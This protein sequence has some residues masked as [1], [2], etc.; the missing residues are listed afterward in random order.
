V[1]STR[2]APPP[3]E[4]LSD[5]HRQSDASV[6]DHLDRRHRLDSDWVVRIAEIPFGPAGRADISPPGDRDGAIVLSTC[7]SRDAVD[8]RPNDSNP[9]SVRYVHQLI[10][11]V[12]K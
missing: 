4:I 5:V 8:V 1:R 6:L 2:H 11:A 10:A 3:R 12:H 9:L 7:E